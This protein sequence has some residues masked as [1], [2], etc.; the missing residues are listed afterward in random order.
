MTNIKRVNIWD[1]DG[2][3]INSMRRL[4][5]CFKPNGD[6]DLDVYRREACTHEA[7]MTDSLLPLVE[8]MKQ[9]VERGE[10]NINNIDIEHRHTKSEADGDHCPDTS[11]HWQ[12]IGFI[13]RSGIIC[14]Y[15]KKLILVE[16]D[17]VCKCKQN[18]ELRVS[19]FFEI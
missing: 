11:R 4:Q 2:T 14:L 18:N 16:L 6:L 13:Y 8:V 3:V 5:Q 17:F 12:S 10:Y 15:H 9:S 1:L 19:S 7:I